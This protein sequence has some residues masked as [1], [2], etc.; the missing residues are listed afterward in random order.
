MVKL[1]V[2]NNIEPI[3]IVILLKI[4]F[5]FVLSAFRFYTA[6]PPTSERFFGGFLLLRYFPTV[7]GFG[8][9]ALVLCSLLMRSAR[10]SDSSSQNYRFG[11][12]FVTLS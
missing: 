4:C 5:G 7:Y 8:L 10:L 9:V 3:E 12:A 1:T 11:A 6:R 2:Q